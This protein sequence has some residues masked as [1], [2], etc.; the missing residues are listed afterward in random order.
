V[1]RSPWVAARPP[2][3]VRS[4]NL[5]EAAAC[6]ADQPCDRLAVRFK[7]GSFS[8]GEG[9]EHTNAPNTH[10]PGERRGPD[11]SGAVWV[12]A[13]CRLGSMTTLAGSIWAPAFAGEVGELIGPRT[14][15][16]TTR[17]NPRPRRII[18]PRPALYA[19]TL[20][21]YQPRRCNSRRPRLLPRKR[22]ASAGRGRVRARTSEHPTSPADARGRLSHQR[23][24]SSPRLRTQG[25]VRP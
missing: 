23:P 17:C 24:P 3:S 6:R 19:A 8:G 7:E 18:I 21:R 2:R 14:F 25:D 10:L 5:L 4:L 16:P 9:R 12:G 20:P 11:S 22:P 15:M 1:G 13:P